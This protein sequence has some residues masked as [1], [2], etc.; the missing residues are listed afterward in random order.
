[1]DLIQAIVLGIVQGA[2]EFI[3]VSSSGHLVLVPWLL[4]WEKPPLIFDTMAH[5]GTLVAVVAY[6]WKDLMK[7]EANVQRD[8]A[9]RTPLASPESRL[10]WLL[11]LA[12]IPT[13]I[14]GLLFEKQF[15]KLFFSEPPYWVIGFL[16]IT[17]LILWIS[18][19]IGKRVREIESLSPGNALLFGLAQSLAITPGISRSGSTISMGLLLGFTRAAAARFSFLMM[20]PVV[21]GA[22]LLKLLELFKTGISGDQVLLLVAGFLSAAISGYVCITF[23]LNFLATRSVRTFAVYCWLFGTL[24]LVL[25]FMRG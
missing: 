4:G 8:L 1:M 5:W 2:T 20:I 6:Y 25:A 14:I 22:G 16:F 7:I 10:A 17:G 23:L 15:E 9:N 3:P 21:F 13:V 18:E 11:V 24:C 12:T 19:S